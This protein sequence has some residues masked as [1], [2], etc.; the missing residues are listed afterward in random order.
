MRVTVSVC[1]RLQR[2]C[3][4]EATLHTRPYRTLTGMTTESVQSRG[5]PGL[6]SAKDPLA[7]QSYSPKNLTMLCC[8]V[9]RCAISTVHPQL[10]QPEYP[11]P[12]L[13]NHQIV[14]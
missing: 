1:S 3:R 10:I 8:A 5:V 2:Q 9:A 13:S 14:L 12:P 11:L 6:P 7:I 4:T